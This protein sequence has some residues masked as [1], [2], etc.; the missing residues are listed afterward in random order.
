MRVVSEVLTPR[1]ERAARAAS[2][3]AVVGTKL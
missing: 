1:P 2:K 3:A